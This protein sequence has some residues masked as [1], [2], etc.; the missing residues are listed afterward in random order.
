MTLQTLKVKLLKC[1]LDF[2]LKFLQS[3]RFD[4]SSCQCVLSELHTW[5]SRQALDSQSNCHGFVS[6]LYYKRN[7]LN[8]LKKRLRIEKH[9]CQQLIPDLETKRFGKVFLETPNGAA[10]K[11]VLVSKKCSLFNSAKTN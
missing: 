2:E 9:L 1:C 7:D 11:R 5:Q 10:N 8:Q 3:F 4:Q 6:H